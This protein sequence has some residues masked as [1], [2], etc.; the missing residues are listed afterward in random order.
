[1]KPREFVEQKGIKTL[2]CF[3]SG[4]KDSLVAT[5]YT[6]GDVEGLDVETFV[7]FVDTTCALPPV[8]QYVEKVCHDLGWP[9]VILRPKEDF[10][11]LAE[12]W[13]MPRRTRRWCC[14]YLKLEPMREFVK[15]LKGPRCEVIGLRREES[16][17]RRKMPQYY[18]FW[19][20]GSASSWKYA[21]IIDWKK[22]RVERYIR[23]HGLPL[24]PT[25][26]ILGRSG[27][28]VCGTY[29]TRRELEAIRA[30]YPEFF[31]RFV[32]L[33]RKFRR[34]GSAFFFRGRCVY[35]KDILRQPRLDDYV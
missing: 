23:E 8:R 11:A 35:A 18:F 1:M 6:L 17:R 5:H 14:Y 31:R 10:W 9:L 34:G 26:S 30:H 3:F 24:N 2:V 13:G 27:E 19:P 16:P 12:K 33:E 21:P 4:G 15:S 32:E 25:Y 22:E 29:T 7:A 20:R 28:C